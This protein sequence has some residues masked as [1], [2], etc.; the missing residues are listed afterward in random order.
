[1]SYCVVAVYIIP[2]R[3]SKGKSQML[4]TPQSSFTFF[5]FLTGLSRCY[6]FKSQNLCSTCRGLKQLNHH[7]VRTRLSW[8]FPWCPELLS[9]LSSTICTHSYPLLPVTNTLPFKK[10]VFLATVALMLALGGN[11]WV[12]ES[13]VQTCFTC[14]CSEII[15]SWYGV[16]KIYMIC[17]L[18]TYILIFFSVCQ[19]CASNSSHHV[20]HGWCISC[21]RHIRTDCFTVSSITIKHMRKYCGCLDRR[22]FSLRPVVCAAL[23]WFNCTRHIFTAKSDQALSFLM[24]LTICL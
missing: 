7:L 8:D 11:S 6:A 20:L 13:V 3:K 2:L 4:A 12:C 1:M 14:N 22:C 5:R 19:S 23:L 15:F 17:T 9:P 24:V 16:E 21:W 18:T 10:T